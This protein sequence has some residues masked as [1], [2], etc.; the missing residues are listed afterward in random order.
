MLAMLLQIAA[1]S[2]I[3]QPL[4]PHVL[5]R[6]NMAEHRSCIVRHSI[7]GRTAELIVSSSYM[8]YYMVSIRVL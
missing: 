2:G 8:L 1:S 4:R 7:N 3:H 6:R 5:L